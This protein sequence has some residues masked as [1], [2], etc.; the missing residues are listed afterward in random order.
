MGAWALRTACRDA[1]TWPKHYRVAV[2][3]SPIQFASDELLEAVRGALTASGLPAERLEVEI[4]EGVLLNNT[5]AAMKRLMAL[6]ELGV[7]IAMDDFGTGYSSLGYLTRFPFSKIKIDQSFLRGEQTPRS[8]ALIQGIIA[9]G[10]RL[11]MTTI[12]EGV[13]TEEHIAQLAEYGCM[14]VQGFLIGRPLPLDGA[15]AFIAAHEAHTT[16]ARLIDATQ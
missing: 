3:V 14:Q 2:N 9:L 16:G 4:T 13:E 12:A 5:D 7:S 15:T 6:K 1:M 8:R 11:G 10:E